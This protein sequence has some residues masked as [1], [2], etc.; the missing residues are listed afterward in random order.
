MRR[1]R[2]CLERAELAVFERITELYVPYVLI[3]CA[4][5]TNRRRQA[6][7]IGAYALVS[8]CFLA[9]EVGP[10]LP[11]GRIVDIVVGVVARD[12]MSRG[13]GEAWWGQS[14]EL[15]FVD[16]RMWKM[17][18]ALN[19]LKG[20]LREAL[21]LHHVCGTDLDDLARLLQKSAGETVARIRRAER[22]LAGRLESLCDEGRGAG[23][24]DVRS[25]L[26]QF[27]A[28]LDGGWMEEVVYCAMD[29]LA[30]C[31]RR[32]RRRDERLRRRV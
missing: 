5:Y 3:R 22:L 28:G 30:T 11:L 26:A 16:A 13:A 1:V 20:P 7:R 17:A 4:R 8:T 18:R 25:W 2:Q 15:L 21:V 14:D 10:V 32:R 6:Q 9:R 31:A 24:A 12:V 23:A 27:A 29:Y 19:S